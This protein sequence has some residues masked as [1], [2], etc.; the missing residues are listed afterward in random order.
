MEFR[1]AEEAD[2]CSI[3]KIIEQAQVYLREQGID[4]W[5]NNYPNKETICKDIDNKISYVLLKD[6]VIIG[7]VA[8]I[9]DGEKTYDIIYDGKW[10]SNQEFAVIHRIAVD[11]DYK[12]LGLATIILNNIEQLCLEK[13][14][15]SIKVDTHY[16]NKSMQQ[17][18][19]KN[20]F[21]FC[22]TIYLEDK[23][24]RMAFEKLLMEK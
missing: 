4:Q 1:R 16:D 8:L 22:G 13:N 17:L 15:Y 12:G 21:Q 11:S 3:M 23:N 7:T 20:N 2:V 5:Q 19:T 9:F 24:K 10:L 6:N 14:I 18:L